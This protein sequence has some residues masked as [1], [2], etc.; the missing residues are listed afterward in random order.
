MTIAMPPSADP[1]AADSDDA[2]VVVRKTSQAPGVGGRPKGGSRFDGHQKI[3][4]IRQLESQ[5]VS[6]PPA[7]G[8]QHG[9]QH[10]PRVRAAGRIVS[11]SPDGKPNSPTFAIGPARFSYTSAK[12][13]L[14]IRIGR[15]AML[16]FGGHRW[17]G[18]RTEANQDR[19]VDDLRRRFAVSRQVAGNAAG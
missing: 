4:Q 5:I 11:S 2:L 19:R 18:R 16:R 8:E 6:S 15:G 3:G 1:N 10:G 7:A 9:Q 13:K 14:V 12:S 17:C